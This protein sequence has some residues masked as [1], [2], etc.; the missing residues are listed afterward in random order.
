MNPPIELLEWWLDLKYANV[1]AAYAPKLSNHAS[2]TLDG[3]HLHVQQGMNRGG[4][5]R[6]NSI[7]SIFLLRI[8]EEP[9]VV[10]VP[11]IL[12]HGNE[13]T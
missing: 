10:L 12:Q 13:A 9:K 5:Y 7:H 2:Q 1:W 11:K 6:R 3:A 4:I 8:S